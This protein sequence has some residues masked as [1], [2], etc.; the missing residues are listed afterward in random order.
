MSFVLFGGDCLLVFDSKVSTRK[1]K[2]K[3]F[4][5]F[6]SFFTQL[7]NPEVISLDCLI[8]FLTKGC[9]ASRFTLFIC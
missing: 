2:D 8:L 3:N 6:T 7:N 5:T 9:I 1:N 4:G